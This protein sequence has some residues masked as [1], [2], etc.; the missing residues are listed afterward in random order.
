MYGAVLRHKTELTDRGEADIGVLFLTNEGYSTMCGHATIALGKFLVDYIGSRSHDLFDASRLL[1]LKPESNAEEIV[2]RL[3]VPCGLV[4]V[5]VPIIADQYGRWQTDPEERISYI[6]VPSFATGRDVQ[7]N[8][9]EKPHSFARWKQLEDRNTVN[10]DVAYGGAF[11]IIVSANELGFP[12]GAPALFGKGS[13]AELRTAADCLRQAFQAGSANR[14]LKR[15]CLSHPSIP[16]MEELYGVI[17]TGRSDNIQRADEVGICFF[18]DQQVDRSPTGSGVQARVALAHA[19]GQIEL[20][21]PLDFESP[22]SDALLSGTFRGE[23]VE[24]VDFGNGRRGV[25]VRV[26]GS[27]SYT[28]YSTFVVDEEDKIGCGFDFERVWYES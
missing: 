8:I 9:R 24:E 19:K 17:V 10:V 13:L 15:Q 22:V 16:E 11:Y 12:Q 27:A 4:R 2:I 7:V 28:G 21:Y 20:D 1:Q 3:H 18:A 25:I 14:D 5:T 26:S 6:S 23:A